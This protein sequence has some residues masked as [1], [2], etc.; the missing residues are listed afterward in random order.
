MSISSSV[1]GLSGHP[2]S[3]VIAIVLVVTSLAACNNSDEDSESSDMAADP[4]IFK[5]LLDEPVDGDIDFLNLP[6]FKR[7]KAG[8]YAVS[9]SA[10]WVGCSALPA[11]PVC[12]LDLDG[13]MFTIPADMVLDV[14][15]SVNIEYRMPQAQIDAITQMELLWNLNGVELSWSDEAIRIRSSQEVKNLDQI[16]TTDNLFQ[17]P[18]WALTYAG[19]DL[20]DDEMIIMHYLIIIRVHPPPLPGE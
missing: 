14:K 18:T 11:T 17:T 6:D 20:L 13:F 4:L 12:N 5:V 7:L 8:K 9:G 19:P 1:N 10:S 3:W 15:V 2:I 16:G